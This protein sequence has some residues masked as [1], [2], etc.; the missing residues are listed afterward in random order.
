MRNCAN[1]VCVLQVVQDEGALTTRAVEL[2]TQAAGKNAKVNLA[3]KELQH[4]GSG[5]SGA[6]RLEMDVAA[7][8]YALMGQQGAGTKQRLSAAFANR[9]KM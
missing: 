8:A 9:S 4:D 2:A 7:K 3:I 6:L 5:V 1:V